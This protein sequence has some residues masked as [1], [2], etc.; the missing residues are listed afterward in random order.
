LK[1]IFA[2]STAAGSIPAGQFIRKNRSRVRK[3]V[4]RATGNYQYTVNAII[5]DMI[6]RCTELNLH[7]PDAKSQETLLEF[8]ATLAL[9]TRVNVQGEHNRIIM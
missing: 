5:G 6:K 9:H 3:T 7:C 1:R 8:A 2:A 4:S